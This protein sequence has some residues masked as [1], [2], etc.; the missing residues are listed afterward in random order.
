MFL[1]VNLSYLL[2]VELCIY[3]SL[4]PVI[5][6]QDPAGQNAAEAEQI[7][8]NI[9][10]QNQ[11]SDIVPP[12]QLSNSTNLTLAATN[13]RNLLSTLDSTQVWDYQILSCDAS[14]PKSLATDLITLLDTFH[15]NLYLVM[16]A[17]SK[18]TRSTLGFSQLFKTQKWLP[19]RRLYENMHNAVGTAG[20]LASNPLLPDHR[21]VF[22]CL[23]PHKRETHAA[24]AICE[25]EPRLRA[26]QQPG[27]PYAIGLCPAFWALPT[28]P[29]GAFCPR[30]GVVSEEY[31][32]E[33]LLLNQQSVLVSMLVRIY[34]GAQVLYPERIGLGEVLALN[35]DDSYWNPST[36][37]YWFA[38]KSASG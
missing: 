18:G 33:A 27:T 28:G 8:Q 4:V 26:Y 23:Q 36:W 12:I 30:K 6:T 19:I 20:N 3:L 2:F 15:Q 25:A 11:Y 37:A 7:P 35:T 31:T 10:S 1:M 5:A 21:P 34:L 38:C 24:Y 16:R 32:G 17:T 9:S 29:V 13:T 22:I 14:E